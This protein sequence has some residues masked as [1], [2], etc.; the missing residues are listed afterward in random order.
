VYKPDLTAFFER[1]GKV[2]QYVGWDDELI[3]PGNSVSS[4]S[5][6]FNPILTIVPSQ[7]KWY[8]DVYAHTMAHSSLDTDDSFR[9][10]TVPGM[11]HCFVRTFSICCLTVTEGGSQNGNGATAFGGWS[12]RSFAPPSKSEA[13]YDSKLDVFL[14]L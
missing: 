5:L 12:Q 13:G 3:A 1:G 4:S 11:M 14:H 9:L 10:F 6:P 2:L 7:I 8:R